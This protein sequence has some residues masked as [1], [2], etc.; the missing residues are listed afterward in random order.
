MT[1]GAARTPTLKDGQALDRLGDRAERWAKKYAKVDDDA[2]FRADYDAK[3]RPE[4]EKLAAQCTLPARS[5]GL[6]EWI[7]ALPLWLIVAGGV[8]GFSV[9][10][11]Q[12]DG[13]WVWLFAA[14]AVLV[15][16]GGFGAV[17][18]DTTSEK[19]AAKRLRDKTEWLL[20]ASRKSANTVLQNRRGTKQ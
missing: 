6:K 20:G 7:I 14:V 18:L 8:F 9:L 13:P 3:F 10:I 17:Y 19:R 11:M 4:A 2:A 1:H 12:P 15:F 16:V 5:F